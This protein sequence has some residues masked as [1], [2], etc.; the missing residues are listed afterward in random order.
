MTLKEIWDAAALWTQGN[1]TLTAL[2]ILAVSGTVQIAPVK[3]YPF[4]WIVK[5]FRNVVGVDDLGKEISKVQG[6]VNDLKGDMDRLKV[7]IR[8]DAEL[9]AAKEARIRILRFCDELL[10][11]I[12]H[13][14]EM[15]GNVLDDITTYNNYCREH[16]EF[17]NERTVQAEATIRRVYQKLQEEKDFTI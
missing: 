6:S 5:Q 17:E 10:N 14:Q 16:P 1:L 13:S 4:R 8:S 9:K 12:R 11:G 3:I 7:E 15:F 2:L